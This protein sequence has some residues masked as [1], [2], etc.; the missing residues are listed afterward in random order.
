MGHFESEQITIS[1]WPIV[2]RELRV[3]ARRRGTYW[4]RALTAVWAIVLFG[5][6]L[7]LLLRENVPPSEQGR[8][9]FLTLFSVGFAHCLFAG[10]GLTA[11]CISK[12]KRDGTLGLLFLTDLKGFD[13]VLGKLAATSL[14]SIYAVLAIVPVVA[15]PVQ[16]GG[17][18]GTELWQAALVLLNTTFFSLSAGLLVSTLS[19]N[20]RKAM[21]A[22]VLIIVVATSLPFVLMFMRLTAAGPGPIAPSFVWPFLVASPAYTFCVVA[23]A[24][25]PVGI[26]FPMPAASFWGSLDGIHLA[27]WALLLMACRVLPSIWQVRA[28]HSWWQRQR[29]RIMQWTFGSAE[30]RR[31]HRARLLEI[32]P[33]L[34]LMNRERAKPFYVWMFLGAMAAIWFVGWFGE[35]GVFML[36]KDVIGPFTLLTAG[37]LKVWV[38]SEACTRLSEDRRIGALE[39]LLSTPLTT[40]EIVRGHWLAFGRQFARPL[41]LLLVLEFFVF[42]MQAGTRPWLLNS[43]LLIADVVT[44]AWLGMWLGLT[45]RNLSRAL[46]GSLACVFAVPWLLFYAIWYI[47]D[48]D[49]GPSGWSGR[50]EVTELFSDYLWLGLRLA[51]DFAFGWWWARRHLLNDFRKAAA[52]RYE[53]KG[54]DWFRR[55]F[56]RKNTA[57]L[58]VQAAA[59]SE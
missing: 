40:R 15:L 32:N 36:D 19:R 24:N 18:T 56:D 39:L 11:D 28:T 42:R 30:A 38:A 26:F 8:Y 45:A 16:L 25:T 52:Q 13:I 50:A 29:E 41:V 4:V 9:L 51:S 5:W 1:M 43:V 23:A 22:T 3:A 6:L 35:G 33:F 2:E 49:P 20:E 34:W 54:P 21:F 10:A 7:L 59:I 53:G 12:E 27:S 55:M 31:R 57:Q 48:V 37:V 14:S 47:L 44:L 46:L 58:P 17:I